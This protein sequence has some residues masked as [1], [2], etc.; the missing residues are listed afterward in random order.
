MKMVKKTLIAITLVAFLASVAPAKILYYG[1]GPLGGGWA[2]KE[3]GVK[4]EGEA[5]V[6]WPYEYV[7]LPVC[8]IP[9]YMEI[10]MY[11]DVKDCK[12]KKIVLQQVDCVEMGRSANE[13]PCYFDCET[14]AV[15][16]NFDVQLGVTKTKEGSVLDQWSAYIQGDSIVPGDGGY[17]NVTVCVKAWRA[18][19]YNGEVGTKVKVGH[20]TITA[21]PDL[22]PD[23]GEGVLPAP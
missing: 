1:F 12:D 21:K 3:A 11:L 9:V 18:R 7:A 13:F 15:R 20:I 6:Y 17:H 14:I 23:W 19:L 4:V 16:A 10:G 2:D 8:E 22:V 5:K